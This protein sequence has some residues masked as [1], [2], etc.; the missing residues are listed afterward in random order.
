LLNFVPGE[1]KKGSPV[2]TAGQ[3]INVGSFQ[4]AGAAPGEQEFY[5]LLL[6]ETMDLIKQ[7]GDSLHFID[8]DIRF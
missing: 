2:G 4:L 7:F 1:S 6:D 8:N 5:M 3:Q